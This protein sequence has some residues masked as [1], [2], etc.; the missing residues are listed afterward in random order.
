[1]NQPRLCDGCYATAVE[2]AANDP[3]PVV[4]RYCSKNQTLAFGHKRGTAEVQSWELYGPLGDRELVHGFSD[5]LGELFAD[6][7]LAGSR[8]A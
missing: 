6:G 3:R 1:V 4:A 8:F 2:I 5:R 7:Q